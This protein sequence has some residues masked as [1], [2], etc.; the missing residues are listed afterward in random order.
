MIFNTINVYNRNIQPNVGDFFRLQFKKRSQDYEI[1]NI[2]DRTI[3]PDGINPLLGKYVWKCNAVR[4]IEDNETMTINRPD[5]QPISATGS[6]SVGGGVVYGTSSSS[7][8]SDDSDSGDS[9]GGGY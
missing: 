8:S 6:S 5:S 3:T 2:V 9:G 7:D 1:T 4:R